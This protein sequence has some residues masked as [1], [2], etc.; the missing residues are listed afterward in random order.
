MK[1]F[2]LPLLCVILLSACGGDSA[3][4]TNT[5]SPIPQPL[6]AQTLLNQATSDSDVAGILAY[7]QTRNDDAQIYVAGYREISSLTPIEQHDQFKIAS[8]SK[9]Y[10]AIAVTR[11]VARERLHLNDSVA[12]WLPEYISS[13]DNLESVT[14][15]H[16]IK[17]RSGIPDFDSQVG[18]SWENPHTDLSQTLAFV[19][20]K[21]A[22]FE[23]NAEYEYSNTNY[24][25]LG[26]IMDRVL[27]FEHE[28]F[29][30]DEILTP[31]SLNNTL[32]HQSTTSNEAM[33]H[34]YWGGIDRIEQRYDIPGGSMVST[35]ADTGRFIRALN[36]GSL[37]E[38]G[39]EAIYPYFYTHSGWL[40][41]YQ[42]IA[43]YHQASNSVIILFV[44]ST[45]GQSESILRQTYDNLIK[46]L[47]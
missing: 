34:G 7:I 24:L 26:L 41:G 38:A 11:L 43:G 21:P 39:E 42:S 19:F 14:I 33:V 20:G 32:L 40:P 18:F 30:Q 23:P 46:T 2:Y 8:I 22:D 5:P 36:D 3:P 37:F 13:I 17:H 31:L 10:I 25:L 47:T 29:I 1:A 16:L 28:I 45:G 44:N 27:G 35:I 15:E 9:L 12:T 4:N 6:D